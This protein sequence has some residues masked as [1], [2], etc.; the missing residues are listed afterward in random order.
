MHQIIDQLI[1]SSNVLVTSHVQ[2]DGDALGSLIAMGLALSACGK[3]ITLYTKDEL[4]KAFRFLPSANRIVHHLDNIDTFDTAVVLDCG[5]LQRVGEMALKINTIPTVI[6][7]DHHITNTGFGNFQIVDPS[8]CATAEI[9][10]R[11]IKEMKIPISRIMAFS[12]YTGIMTDTGSFRFSNT[13]QEAFAICEEMVGLGVDPTFVAGHVSVTY[14]LSRIKL[15]NMVLESIEVS[16]NGRLSL[17][18]LT[19]DMLNKTN[20]K[21]EDLGRLINY[22][23]HIENVKV[24][25][26]IFE[27]KNGGSFEPDSKHQFHISLRSDGTVNVAEIASKYGGGGHKSAAGFNMTTTLQTIRSKILRLADKL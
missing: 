12:I 16:E 14:S 13:N 27:S 9:I 2:P 10:Y 7:I 23:R 15:L 18:T 3:K 19:Q 4:P 11:L 21:P 5:D 6:N 24:A 20:S 17:M 1:K 26:L 22:A 8:A 25:A